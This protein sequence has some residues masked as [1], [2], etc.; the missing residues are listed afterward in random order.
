MSDPFILS[1]ISA[2]ITPAVTAWPIPGGGSGGGGGGGGG[3]SYRYWRIFILNNNG[4]GNYTALNE[5]ELRGSVGG[6]DITTPATPVT[7]SS[8]YDG[9][10]DPQYTVDNLLSATPLWI[11][12]PL[13]VTNQWLRYDLGTPI[14]IAQVA[15]CFNDPGGPGRSPKDLRI[16]GSNDGTSF[17]TV[18][19]FLGNTSW[20]A[21]GVFKV[22][23]L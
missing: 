11:S 6:A 14:A 4:D 17:T 8:Q 13:G 18:K 1:A 12:T 23:D 20:P 5:V 3:A 22:F 16:E 21:G 19:T 15:M 9:T 7:A 2:A 10:Y